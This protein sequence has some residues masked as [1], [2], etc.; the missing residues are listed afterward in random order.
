MYQAAA[1][2]SRHSPVPAV[3][4]GPVALKMAELLVQLGLAHSK[5]AFPSPTVNQDEKF[6]SLLGGS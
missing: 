1:L 5:L 6:F 3:N 2:M 4:P